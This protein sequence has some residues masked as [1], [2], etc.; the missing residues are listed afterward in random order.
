LATISGSANASRRGR[1]PT[2]APCRVR[3]AR[4]PAASSADPR[5]QGRVRYHGGL[6]S[7]IAK[8]EDAAVAAGGLHAAN[9]CAHIWGPWRAGTIS[10]A[11]TRGVCRRGGRESPPDRRGID[12]RAASPSKG[13][14]RAASARGGPGSP[15][16][17]V[18]AR[19]APPARLSSTAL[20]RVAAK[21][22][23][24]WRSHRHRRGRA[25]VSVARSRGRSRRV[26]S[27]DGRRI[28]SGTAA[29]PPWRR[30]RRFG[31]RRCR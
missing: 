15:I 30:P 9:A 10:C 27:T 25:R 4:S 2:S 14:D 28:R 20:V 26:P 16:W 8:G 29:A 17:V 24:P 11:G 22:D 19:A 23:A 3:Q 13:R 18:A 21:R 5:R 6:A 31:C 1:M 7:D 12:Q